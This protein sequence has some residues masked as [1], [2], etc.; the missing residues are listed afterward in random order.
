M[1]C[2]VGNNIKISLDFIFVHEDF[3]IFINNQF[4]FVVIKK[5]LIENRSFVDTLLIH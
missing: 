2:A 5:Q 4:L 1:V 3:N